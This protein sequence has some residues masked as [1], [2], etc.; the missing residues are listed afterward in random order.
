MKLAPTR[1]LPAETM[2]VR[3]W[4]L[5]DTAAMSG[6]GELRLLRRGDEFSMRLGHG[7]LM[8]SRAHASEEAL[9]T[10]ACGR[11]TNRERARILIGGLGMGFT[12]RAA[13]GA[14]GAGARVVVAELVPQVVAWNRG[15]MAEVFGHTLADGRVDIREADVADLIRSGAPAY[16]A[17]LLDVDDGPDGPIRSANARLYDEKGLALARAALLPAGILAVWSAGPDAAFTPRLQRAGFRVEEVPVRAS[18]KRKGSRHTI[19]IAR[20]TD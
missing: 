17:I 4:T 3:P 6:G 15:S 8:N 18:G 2:A 14:L 7:E 16:D 10:I 11:I 9:A 19:W 5:L 12:L 13:L 1:R 20:R